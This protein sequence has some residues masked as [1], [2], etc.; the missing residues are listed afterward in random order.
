[1]RAKKQTMDADDRLTEDDD[2]EAGHDT[3]ALEN[4]DIDSD[5]DMDGEVD[6]GG[7]GAIGQRN[8]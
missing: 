3:G 1:M 4:T 8:D 6:A 2:S 5:E 7:A